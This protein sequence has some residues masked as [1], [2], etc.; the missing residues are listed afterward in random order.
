MQREAHKNDFIPYPTDRVVGTIADP[1][2]AR[3]AIEALG[4]AGFGPDH[5]DVLHGEEALH[6]LDP[7]GNEHGLLAQFQ[8]T[9]IRTAGPAEE[10]KHLKQHVDDVRAGKFVIMVLAKD[11]RKRDLA[12]EI[13]NTHGAESV[14]FYGRWAYESLSE[15]KPVAPSTGSAAGLSFETTID[16]EVMTVGFESD[17]A[18]SVTY[19]GRDERLRAAVA[20]IRPDVVLLS[21]Q[22]ADRTTVI[23]V[24]DVD[25]GTAHAVKVDRAG[26][27]RHAAGTL[28]RVS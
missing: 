8:R 11:H 21:W 6:R 13:L 22:D 20:W 28:R 5:I 10:Y 23:H 26:T 16:G 24:D 12:V 2:H 4:R 3:W 25:A 14:G 15:N 17:A 27:R 18:A 19:A 7:T 9:L 1:N